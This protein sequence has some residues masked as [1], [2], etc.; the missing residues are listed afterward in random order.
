MQGAE[1]DGAVGG[2][3][4]AEVGV[5]ARAGRGELPLV[6]AAERVDAGE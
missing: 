6:E 3:E 1:D 5:A 4:Q 2:R